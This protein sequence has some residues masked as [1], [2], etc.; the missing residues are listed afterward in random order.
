MPH[1][2]EY[3][4]NEQNGRSSSIDSPE[5]PGSP[6]THT[7]VSWLKVAE[8]GIVKEA[9]VVHTRLFAAAIYRGWLLLPALGIL[10]VLR[11]VINPGSVTAALQKVPNDGHEHVRRHL[12]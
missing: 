1:E 10:S 12:S 9:Q 8:Y 5:S 3:A 2:I 4:S 7:F 11:L 6:R